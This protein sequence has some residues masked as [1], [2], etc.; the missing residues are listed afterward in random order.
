MRVT[1]TWVCR[2]IIIAM[3]HINSICNKANSFLQ[4]NL[5][6]CSAILKQTAYKHLVLSCREY[7]ASLWDPSQTSLIHQLEMV[8][9]RAACFVL[10]PE[11]LMTV[12]LKC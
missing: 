1:V 8:Q 2:Y 10:G 3:E 7:C 6:H 4:R 12:F 11:I 9:H 5:R